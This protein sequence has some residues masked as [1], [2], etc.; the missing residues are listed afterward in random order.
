MT[1]Q[2]FPIC[3]Y[4]TPIEIRRGT[5][6]R[7]AAKEHGMGQIRIPKKRQK[8]RTEPALDL[9]TPAGRLLPF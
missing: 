9:R 4:R 2:D 1:F 7:G 5:R 8:Q 3:T 6:R